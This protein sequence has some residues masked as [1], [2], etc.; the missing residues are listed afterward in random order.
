MISFITLATLDLSA[1]P[2]I[3]VGTNI[4]LRSHRNRLLPEISSKI[5]E[6]AAEDVEILSVVECCVSYL[7]HLDK[8][9]KGLRVNSLPSQFYFLISSVSKQRLVN[10]TSVTELCNSSC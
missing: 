10:L 2:L 4:F 3:A 6:F 1:S 5:S 8:Q 9:N 7:T